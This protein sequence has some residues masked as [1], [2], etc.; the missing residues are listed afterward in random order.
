MRRLAGVLFLAAM[1]GGCTMVRSPAVH[2]PVHV[3][4]PPSQVPNDSSAT[5]GCADCV[6]GLLDDAL[7]V[8]STERVTE[9]KTFGGDCEAYALVLE[10]SLR[11]GRVV[12]R[13]FMWR[14]EGRLVSGAAQP[15]GAIVVAR[16]IDPLNVGAR[17]INDVI[18]TLEH[19]A[20]H[21]AFGI[22][23][24]RDA[25]DDQANVLV[26]GCRAGNGTSR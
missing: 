1:A 18:Q 10:A 26:R 17:S 20:A 12:V 13:P 23:N 4:A 16:H 8:R 3:P 9:L 2:S 21:V 11:S 5:S 24:G 19:E 14:V 15:D 7:L 22:T 6:D 25:V